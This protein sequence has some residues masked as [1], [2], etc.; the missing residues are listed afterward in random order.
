MYYVKDANNI[1][2]I[3]KDYLFNNLDEAIKLQKDIWLE[4][5]KIDIRLFTIQNYLKFKD[6]LTLKEKSFILPFII[7]YREY[8]ETNSIEHIQSLQD[9]INR[10][11]KHIEA[12]TDELDKTKKKDKDIIDRCN[13]LIA[14]LETI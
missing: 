14:E 12:Y 7:N 11:Y 3:D 13:K 10:D 8:F 6:L 5:I 4:E 1:V 9:S 2:V